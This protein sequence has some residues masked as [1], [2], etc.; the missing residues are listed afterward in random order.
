MSDII[1]HKISWEQFEKDCIELAKKIKDTHIDRIIAISRG[2]LVP[3]RILSDLLN[4]RISHITISTYQNLHQEKEPRI[5]EK[6]EED[7]AGKS[8]LIVDDISDTGNTFKHAVEHFSNFKDC[9]IYTVSPYIKSKTI[10][11]P[12]FWEKKLDAWIIFPYELKETKDAFMN[13]FHSEEKMIEKLKEVGY[14]DWEIEG[15]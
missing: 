1:F 4:I 12:T 3:A 7:F 2:G 11:I 5:T 6:P 13:M 8:I 10:H 14:E 9:K 15:I